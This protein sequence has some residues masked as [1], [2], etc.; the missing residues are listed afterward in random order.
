MKREISPEP[1]TVRKRVKLET[2]PSVGVPRRTFRRNRI[3]RRFLRQ[4]GYRLPRVAPAIKQYVARAVKA[5]DETKVVMALDDY[6]LISG[7]STYVW[8][9]SWQIAQ[10]GA[11]NQRIG[12]KITDGRLSINMAYV[13]NGESAAN[14]NL[15]SSSWVRFIVVRSRHT[16]TAGVTATGMQLNPVGLQVGNL[17]RFSAARNLVFADIE[18]RS[19]TVIMDHKW[20]A[21]RYLDDT[22]A[23]DTGGQIT[24]KHFNVPLPKN[25]TYVSGDAFG[26]FTEAETYVV[27]VCGAS[28]ILNGVITT[29]GALDNVGVM[30]ITGEI[31]F[32]D[33]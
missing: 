21:H 23:G 5:D 14:V 28:A 26:Y 25:L 16:K 13:H 4:R 18:T 29:A 24:Y 22:I 9:P 12:R 8:T 2:M 11:S 10:G 19:W 31:L 17:F 15:W 7:L 3:A 27:V 33:A 32:K 1:I 20:E 30:N 6:R